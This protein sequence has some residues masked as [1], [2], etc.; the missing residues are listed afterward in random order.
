MPHYHLLP[1]LPTVAVITYCCHHLHTDA[2]ILLLLLLPYCSY[3]LLLLLLL[4]FQIANKRENNH[5]MA[6]ILELS[7][8][9][10]A[11]KPSVDFI[12]PSGVLLFARS[13]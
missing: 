11:M 12:G 6:Q 7:P 10:L 2:T 9:S 8:V 13:F 4:Y 5:M 3:Y 1:L